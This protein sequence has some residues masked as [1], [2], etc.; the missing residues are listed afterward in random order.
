MKG[1]QNLGNTCY[2]NAGLQ[3][4][5]QNKDLCSVILQYGNNSRILNII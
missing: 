4:L 1:L 3:I 5:I 2:L